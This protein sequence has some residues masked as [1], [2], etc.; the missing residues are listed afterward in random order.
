MKERGR[1]KPDRVLGNTKPL[2]QF[3]DLPGPVLG[4]HSMRIAASTPR[5]RSYGIK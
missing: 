2:H 5:L 1:A 3:T 4:E